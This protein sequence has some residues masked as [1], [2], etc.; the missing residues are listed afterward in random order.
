MNPAETY[1]KDLTPLSPVGATHEGVTPC[2][3]T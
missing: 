3:L 2:V 1:F